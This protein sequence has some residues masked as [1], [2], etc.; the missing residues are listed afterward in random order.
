MNGVIDIENAPENLFAR[1]S[2]PFVQKSLFDYFSEELFD[3]MGKLCE[4]F[5]DLSDTVTEK[6]LNISREQVYAK[7][8]DVPVVENS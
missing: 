1:F 4:P 8:T 5:E 7:Y 2:S 3:D 6:E